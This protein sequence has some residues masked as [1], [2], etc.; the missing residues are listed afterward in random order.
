[1]NSLIIERNYLLDQLTSFKALSITFL[2]CYECWDVL[3]YSEKFSSKL[4]IIK[5][6][7]IKLSLF[8]HYCNE[9]DKKLRFA[10]DD[11]ENFGWKL[12]GEE[13][14]YLTDNFSA[15]KTPI[16]LFSVRRSRDLF[17]LPSMLPSDS[18]KPSSSPRLK[19]E[20]KITLR[21]I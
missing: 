8:P 4:K 10:W 15:G 12:I 9:L 18:G 3:S 1:M 17:L 19:P 20:I 6:G 14:F 16:A 2:Y 7:H 21:D 11:G 5:R 13:L